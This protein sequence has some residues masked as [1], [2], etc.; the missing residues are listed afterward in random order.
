LQPNPPPP[1][2]LL[3]H[4]GLSR[5]SFAYPWTE[6]LSTKELITAFR[7]ARYVNLL[8]KVQKTPEDRSLLERIQ[9]THRL[10]TLMKSNHTKKMV[11]VP[12][13]AGMERIFFKDAISIDNCPGEMYHNKKQYFI[14]QE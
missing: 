1:P 12:T 5:G 14:M 7:L 9:F 3:S 6:A 11:L 13:D 8:K 4:P 10:H 2:P